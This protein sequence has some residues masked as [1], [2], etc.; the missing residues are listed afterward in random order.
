MISPTRATLQPAYILHRYPYRDTSLLVEA[1]TRDYGRLGLVARGARR[2]TNRQR[3]YMQPFRPL[4][5]S[6]SGRSEL[7]T[8]TGCESSGPA[9]A[10]KGTLLFSG[11]YLNELLLRLLPR[12]DPHVDLFQCYEKTLQELGR[13]GGQRALRLF[14][15]RLLEELGYGLQL[16]YDVNWHRPL[17]ADRAYEFRLEHGPFAVSASNRGALC[18]SGKSLISLQRGELS[19]AQ[20][21][22]DA[23]RLMRAALNLYLGDRPLKTREVLRQVQITDNR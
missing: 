11:F 9:I 17:E 3:P 21:L 18:F 23:K 20:S 16:E 7:S 2:P 19:D 1:F 4:L 10:L 13:D 14:E 12:Q 5:I 8:L 15:K 22:R 6:Y